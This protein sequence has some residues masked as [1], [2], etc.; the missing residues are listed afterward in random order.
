M[1]FAKDLLACSSDTVDSYCHFKRICIFSFRNSSW[2][3]LHDAAGA[4]YIA[5]LEANVSDL[6]KQSEIED[7]KNKM[8]NAEVV[9][10]ARDLEAYKH[11]PEIERLQHLTTSTMTHGGSEVDDHG[12]YS[13]MM[14][15]EEMW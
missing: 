6:E 8:L 4:A 2:D 14:T 9:R 1:T 11:R 10:M 15:P 13:R 3:E 7:Q 12:F 5:E